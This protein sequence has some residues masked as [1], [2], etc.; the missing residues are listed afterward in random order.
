MLQ[1]NYGYP[2]YCWLCVYTAVYVGVGVYV[3]VSVG[4]SG[5]S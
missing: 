2:V 3:G 1:K 5:E 4:Y